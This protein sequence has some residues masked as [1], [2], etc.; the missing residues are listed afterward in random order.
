MYGVLN[1][2][3]HNKNDQ[4]STKPVQGIQYFVMYDYNTANEAVRRV[5]YWRPK[6]SE[7][8]LTKIYNLSRIKGYYGKREFYQPDYDRETG[9]RTIPDFRNTLFWDPLV[10][11]DEQGE[12]TISFFCSDLNSDF[13][14][15]IEG[16]SDDGLLGAGYVKFTVRNLNPKP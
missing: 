9:E 8:D 16:V 4:G 1:C 13:T 12:A 5:T 10:I 15:R 2:P 14:G 11:T 3:R 7:D 6:Y